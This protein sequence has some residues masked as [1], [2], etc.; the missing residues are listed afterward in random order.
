MER[1]YRELHGHQ[2][3]SWLRIAIARD[4]AGDA[5]VY[6]CSDIHENKKLPVPFVWDVEFSDEDIL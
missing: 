2:L 5:T 3:Q 6:T 4:E 1:I